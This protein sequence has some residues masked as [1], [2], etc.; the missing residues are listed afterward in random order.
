MARTRREAVAWPTVLRELR[1]VEVT[2]VSAT[3]RR[4]RLTGEQLRE[5]PVSGGTAAAF[6]S[7]GFDD[8]VKLFVPME[9]QER[10]PLPVQGPDRLEWGGAGGRPVAKDYTPRRFVPTDDGGLLDLDFVLHEGGFAAGWAR[11]TK[12]GDPAW[13]VGPTRSLRLPEGVDRIVMAADETALPAVGRFL[14]EWTASVAVDIIVDVPSPASIQQL[15]ERAGVSL[16]WVHG[17]EA[18]FD[19]VASL[20]WPAVPTFCWVAGEAG[21]VRRVRRLLSD[22]RA[23]PRDCLD[24][25]GYWRR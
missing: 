14:D 22:E 10:P 25:T 1:V 5:F 6:R 7:T 11:R 24:A 21:A 23:V 20:P 19:A 16:T 13:I 12:P 9:G 17:A 18:W 3:T 15:P 4:V 8:H 2:D